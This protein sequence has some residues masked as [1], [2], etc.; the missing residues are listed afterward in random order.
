MAG[1]NTRNEIWPYSTFG[2]VVLVGTVALML[3]GVNSSVSADIGP[4]LAGLALS[5]YVFR[6]GLPWRWLNFLFL[7]SFLIVGM[8][9]GQPGLMWM[10]GYLAGAQF[11]V[12][13]RLTAKKSKVKATW[14]VNGRGID[15]L[16]EARKV[17]RQE[18]D[19]LDGERH[20]RLVVEHG[21]ARF[22]VAGSMPSSLV[23]HRNHD[24]NNDFSW[25]VLKN[26]GQTED[27]SVEVPIGRIEGFIPSRYVN[28]VGAVDKALKE[29]LK[30]PTA[31]PP[32]P[33]WDT[34]EIAFDLRLSA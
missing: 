15:T 19:I 20:H 17:A 22:E 28:D 1:K 25:A 2:V 6:F 9:L 21:P 31:A 23:C 10:G 18:L 27:R 24:A 16:T 32:G 7:A 13:W 33:E 8:L 12:A 29:F 26:P 14:T 4:L 11:G 5:T 30:N 34:A 3:F